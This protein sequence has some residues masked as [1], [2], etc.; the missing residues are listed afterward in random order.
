[1]NCKICQSNAR[2]VKTLTVRDTHQ[3]EYYYCDNCGFMFVGNPTWLE[4]AYKEPINITDTGYVMRNVY[5]SR[6]TLILF[7]FIFG[8]SKTYLDFAG[9]YGMFT[10]LMRDYGMNF[11]T[12]DA[13][14]TNLFAKG[15]E[16]KGKNEQKIEAIT[17]FECFEHL[18]KPAEDIAKM[19]SIS[20]NIF[21]STVL[22]PP[23]I[24]PSDDWEYYGLNHGQHVAFYSEKTLKYIA[25]KHGVN[26]Q[27]NGTNLHLFTKKPVSK[28]KF[29]TLLWL[30]KIQFD[31][32][33]RKILSSKTVSD[34]LLL[35]KE[36]KK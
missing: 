8:K 28:F 18:D 21:F 30:T 4:E 7:Y 19:F 12:D 25:K 32:F 33:I 35:K 9:G 20:S 17:C 15:F 24:P 3:A 11:F 31:I 13:Y 16:Y 22:L 29:L 10:R 23:N 14:T 26:V 1:M 5:L 36:G 6:K 27:T 34:H 2:L